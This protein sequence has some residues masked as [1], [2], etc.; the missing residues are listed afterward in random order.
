LAPDATVDDVLPLLLDLLDAHRRAD[1]TLPTVL[2]GD[3]AGGALVLVMAGALRD[4]TGSGSTTANAGVVG[5]VGLSPWLDATLDEAEVTD[6]EPSDPMLAETG[7][8]A[9][10][11]WWA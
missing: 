11:R 3:S 4:R 8:R 1:P 5:V 10:G 7:L 2:M 6:L 9:A